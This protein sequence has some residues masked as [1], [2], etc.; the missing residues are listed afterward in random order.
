M[1]G[2][3]DVDGTLPN[4]S[5]MKISSY[6]KSLGENVE[7]VRPDTEYEKIYASAIFMRSKPIC[8]SLI[9]KYGTRIEIG[10]T[11]WDIQKRLPPEIEA[12][13]TDYMLYSAELVAGRIRGIMNRKARLRKAA[14][15]TEAGI[16][17]TSRGCVRCCPFCL[18]QAKE[19]F[20][21]QDQEIRDIINPKS[22]I[23]ILHDNNFTAD[24][25]CLEKLREI[26][27]RGLIVDINQGCD[28]RL[29]TDEIAAALASVRHLRSV[30]YAWDLMEYED[31]VINGIKTLS[32]FVKPYRHM[33]YMLTGFN[34]SFE[35]DFY[36]F[37][38]LVELKIKPYVMIYNQIPDIRLKHFARWV[39]AHI[40][41][42][43]NFKDYT[44]W[45]KAQKEDLIK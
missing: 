3:I 7:F 33:C 37:R 17:F 36:R 6:F 22:N 20:L 34:T 1:I 23:I 45:I 41:T 35:E 39:N 8:E 13:K 27:E 32:K 4:F 24:P 26:R 9:E 31:K 29:M 42:Q 18:V 38:K 15:I 12:C 40:H 28:V 2:L 5:L 19:G 25:Y 30:H 10:G 11:G 21:R 43:C 16:G 44:P 14:Q